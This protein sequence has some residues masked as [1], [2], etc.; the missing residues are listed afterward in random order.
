MQQNGCAFSL[1][2]DQI[3]HAFWR[4]IRHSAIYKLCHLVIHSR[5]LLNHVL[6]QTAHGLKMQME[7]SKQSGPV[8]WKQESTTHLELVYTT[9][10]WW[11]GAWFLLVLPTLL[12][13][14]PA[15]STFRTFCRRWRASSY[16]SACR[17]FPQMSSIAQCLEKQ[18]LLTSGLILQSQC[19]TGICKDVLNICA[20]NAV[21]IYTIHA[22]TCTD[23]HM[24]IK[25]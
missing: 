5:T 1:E 25:I 16:S 7:G 17:N 11:F 6:K 10:L 12:Q 4:T 21:C 8:W 19:C 24:S 20:Y 13:T 9:D 14:W 18:K 15:W 3:G 22:C 23:K 2:K